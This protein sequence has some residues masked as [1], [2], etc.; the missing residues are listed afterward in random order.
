MTDKQSRQKPDK[1]LDKFLDEN[2]TNS[3]QIPWQKTGQIPEKFLVRNIAKFGIS[4]FCP[5]K[6]PVKNR[7]F[8]FHRVGS[9]TGKSRVE[10]FKI[11]CTG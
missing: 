11:I 4:Y 9:G 10:Q 2:W 7:T 5:E 1:L 3:G 6:I 8:F